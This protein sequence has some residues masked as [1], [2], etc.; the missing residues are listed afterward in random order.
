[1]KAKTVMLGIGIALTTFACS[2]SGYSSPT[3]PTPPPSSG[4]GTTDSGGGG[5]GA[6][7]Q[8]ITILSQNG[9]QSFSPNPASMGGQ[10]VVFRNADSIVH[11]VILNNGSVDTGDIALRTTSR[12]VMMPAAGGNYHCSLHPDMVGTVNP[13]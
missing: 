2:G 7:T 10:M 11:R 8:T 1:M 13:S 9:A 5:G 3:T 12:A 6:T 4:G